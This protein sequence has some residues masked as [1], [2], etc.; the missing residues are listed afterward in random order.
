[1]PTTTSALLLYKVITLFQGTCLR[2]VFS[3]AASLIAA[4]AFAQAP[5]ITSFSPKSGPIGSNITITGTGFNTTAN[6]NIVL[7]GATQAAVGAASATSLAV[8]V[9]AG[10]TYEYISVTNL[11]VNLTAYSLTHFATALSGSI[12]FAGK[13]D[14]TTGT[15]PNSIA[16]GDFDGDGKPDIAVANF[17]S[18]SVS[19][20]R[21]TS[22]TGISSFATKVDFA[23]GTAPISVTIGDFDG[24]GKPDLAAANYTDNTVSVL[25]N[26]SE[27]GTVAFE[28]KVDLTA[29]TNPH[30]VAVGDIDRDGKPD[31]AVANEGSGTVSVFLNA[32]T[33]GT[34][35]FE[36]KVDLSTD[37]QPSSVACGDINGD[38]KP[39][40][41][42]VNYGSNTLSVFRNNS[43]AGSL[44]FLPKTDFTTN[45][46]P[47]F[48]CIGDIDGDGKPDVTVTNYDDDNVS[49][50][51]N[52]STAVVSFSSKRDL[53]V[54]SSPRSATLGDING[55]GKPDLVVAN[56]GD[57]SVS[58]IRNISTSGDLKF[59][60]KVDFETGTTP[61]FGGVADIDADG[62]PDLAIANL[63]S[64]SV[65]V[66][67]QLIVEPPLIDSFSPEGGS[68]GTSVTI[69]GSGFSQTPS[70]NI[71]FF[72][73]TQ[74]EVTASSSTSVTAT[75]PL[76][77]THQ[78]ISVTNLETSLTAF[79]TKPYTATFAGNVAFTTDD[80]ST[81]GTFESV[82]LGDFDGD[83]KPDLAMVQSAVDLVSVFRNTSTNGDISFA[84]KVDFGADSGPTAIHAS[85]IDGDGKLDL[86]IANHVFRRVTVYRNI[87]TPGN[88][89][90]EYHI[91]D[92]GVPEIRSLSIG[93]MDGDGRPDV[94]VARGIYISILPNASTPGI[95]SFAAQRDLELGNSAYSLRVGDIDGDEKPDLVFTFT[96][97]V[98]VLRNASSAGNF[99]FETRV[100][101]GVDSQPSSV[102][103]GDMDGDGKPDLA[104]TSNASTVSVVH[105]TS[106]SGTISFGDRIDFTRGNPNP[107]SITD[108]NGDGKPDLVT[109][110]GDKATVFRSKSSTGSLAFDVMVDIASGSFSGTLAAGDLDAD[111]KPDL[112]IP[113]PSAPFEVLRQI[114]PPAPT[115]TS[116]TP[117]G[118]CASTTTVVI[119]G[120]DLT[121][122]TSVT[123]GGT[124]ALEFIVNSSTQITAEVGGGATGLIS[125]TTGT[126]TATSEESFS[127]LNI[128]AVPEPISGNAVACAGSSNTYS[129]AE[130]SGATSYTWTLPSG[131][132]GSST[133]SSITANATTT[134]GDISVIANNTCGSSAAQQL[135]I[136]VNTPPAQPGIISIDGPPCAGSVK[137]FSISSVANATSYTWTLPDGWTGASST[138][139][140]DVTIGTTEG[141]ISVVANNGACASP[142]LSMLFGIENIPAQPDLIEGDATIC[143][144]G[145]HEYNTAFVNN[146]TSYTWT[147][148]EGWSGSSNSGTITATA[149]ENGGDVSVTANNACGSSPAQILT[150][151]IK[152]PPAQPGAIGGNAVVCANSTNIYSVSEVA[153]ATSYTWTLPNGWIGSSLSN[154]INVTATEAGGTISVTANN[155]C[156][157]PSTQQTLDVAIASQPSQPGTI[158]G[159]VSICGNSTQTYSIAEV[160]GATS[161]T[162]TF[163]ADWIG[164]GLTNS[165]T[166][167]SG[168]SGTISVTANACGL[169]SISQ[170]LE[171]TVTDPPA[172]APFI[173]GEPAICSGG[174]NTYS[175]AE[176]SGAAN[177]TWTL[178]DGWTGTSDTNS[179]TVTA[180][181][182]GGVL[183]VQANSIDGCSS[184]STT[185]L[186][187]VI[188]NV[189]SQPG[190][191]TGPA[192]TCSG[193]EGTFTVDEVSGA[194]TYT[195]MLPAG[196]T[197]TST[198]NSIDAV[199]GDVGGDITVTANNACGSS[200]QQTISVSATTAPA[201]PGSITGDL[202]VCPG[203]FYQ[204]SIGSVNG[205]TSYTWTLPGGWVGASTTTFIHAFTNAT[206]G[207]V[208]VAATNDCGSSAVQTLEI[209]TGQPTVITGQPE[210]ATICAG[211]NT[212]FS[213]LATG[214]DLIYKWE[215]SI[216][217][218]S[219]SPIDDDERHSGTS[220]AT[221]EIT[222][223]P[224][225]SNIISYRCRVTGGCASV[226]TSEFATLT[227]QNPEIDTQ[228]TGTTICA[229]ETYTLSVSASDAASF[230]WQQNTGS[231]FTDIADGGIYSGAATADLTLTGITFDMNGYTY[232]CVV[233]ST[234]GTAT[235]N[236]AQI[237]VTSIS[238]PVITVDTSNPEA[239]VL[240]STFGSS[241]EWFRNGTAIPGETAG[242]LTV[243]EE[244]SYTVQV[245]LLGCTSEMSA[246]LVITVTGLVGESHSEQFL[247]YPN[248][249]FHSVVISLHAFKAGEEVSI[250]MSDMLGR[251]LEKTHGVGN[252]SKEI[253]VSAL[254]SGRYVV[255]LQQGNKK[256]TAHFL[257]SR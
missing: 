177:Y 154:S 129:V 74:A 237:A 219:F 110:F 243:T 227:V 72:G 136:V 30:S 145:I 41:A 18:S 3:A 40:L 93:D 59:V 210:N 218:G 193:S 137:T 232:R 149:S 4:I 221:L 19:V 1:M 14:M 170:T 128:P 67:Q 184:P 159:D 34:L 32:S 204:Y 249:A 107:V 146:V 105:N 133:T 161:Y 230:K 5:T 86:V 242:T 27:P 208:T 196:W 7:F 239:P 83:N 21:N 13:E 202:I 250:V 164:T 15:N 212:S 246:E 157:V 205:A 198:T 223:F 179:I 25:L 84:E 233:T 189:P 142:A 97:T 199:A 183:S 103:V 22:T 125:V 88:L 85:D 226:A 114:V 29:G 46:S 174:S 17:N 16:I 252:T 165:V 106:T 236:S 60:D 58:V 43:T 224:I 144:G 61:Y 120:T 96:N 126:G 209:S 122:A 95:V 231:G 51:R 220:T 47:V 94:V 44:A 253:D 10:A 38:L 24:D 108:F 2:V 245:S 130:V 54:G 247:I 248:P 50:F 214:D 124:N 100:G 225:T 81:T 152:A 53:V 66:L 191:M 75:V 190:N 12:S 76:C 178:P 228:P 256:A 156:A 20:L 206:G 79:T 257:R 240:T 172:A 181:S 229:G 123:F 201:E 26:S 82:A 135:T 99:N 9:P 216:I 195:W 132:T 127:V 197:G 117:S 155:S 71:V 111:G 121:D 167:V 192:A 213:V 78:Y 160:P 141:T 89:D 113:V 244:G 87:S 235:S 112:V 222:G 217:G 33:V 134:G 163:P 65:S 45:E 11:A 23:T 185:K 62:R 182:E 8:T 234:C 138:E 143:G 90:F 147:L 35:G 173:A 70:Q 251:P 77:T 176:A 57:A 49:V 6:Q 187:E 158:T 68:F 200:D 42:V 162:W 150:V 148:P 28:A 80:A 168:V 63:G 118:G 52:T 207:I 175:I 109:H 194:T 211:G 166:V 101:Y 64:N 36:D 151:S 104:F 56:S 39:D 55:D 188:F 180:D 203:D 171:V 131:W 37:T 73:T 115:V 153:D 255:S 241:Y 98:S 92:T 139:T 31:L 186:I 102:T 116:F 91:F 254:P 69:S 140:I 119:T 169:Q 215:Q 48:V 238:K